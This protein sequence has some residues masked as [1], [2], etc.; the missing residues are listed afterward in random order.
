MVS[1]LM[2]S[3]VRILLTMNPNDVNDDYDAN[4]DDHDDSDEL[5]SH[6]DDANCMMIMIV[7]SSASMLQ[8]PYMPGPRGLRLRSF[9][10]TLS[11]LV[12]ID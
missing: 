11:M 10:R 12:M 4:L 8:C 7:T 5:V 3:I 2:V 9:R 1:M 6:D